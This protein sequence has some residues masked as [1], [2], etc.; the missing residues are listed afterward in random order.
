M[1]CKRD[2]IL[3]E[4]FGLNIFTCM[5]TNRFNNFLTR[6]SLFFLACSDGFFGQNCSLRCDK[7]CLGCNSVNGLCNNECHP[8]WTGE[9]CDK[10]KVLLYDKI[11][12]EYNLYDFSILCIMQFCDIIL[13]TYTSQC[14]QT[15]LIR[16]G[17][18]GILVPKSN[19]T[20]RRI[21]PF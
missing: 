3:Y 8:G 15:P 1:L 4:L 14:I 10:R 16:R 18:F 9:N 21:G 5:Y 20:F 19:D 7:R 13:P 17:V 11:T 12:Q 2:T 6:F